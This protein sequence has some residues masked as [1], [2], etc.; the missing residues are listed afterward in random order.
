L[1]FLAE[2]EV[3]KR[4]LEDV[5]LA[6]KIAQTEP[7]RSLIAQ[8]LNPGIQ[9]TSDEDILAS[10]KN[11][12]D[13]YEHPFSSAPMGPESSKTAAVDFSGK[14]YRVKGLRVVDASIFPDAVSEA[15]NP[16]VIMTAEKIAD[17]I[18]NKLDKQLLK[19]L[20]QINR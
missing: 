11:T 17:E 14:V 2:E 10:I 7:L 9:V 13:S 4:I 19:T 8:E 12:L 15:P 5:K 16:T 18:K 3:R 20:T 1:N 6:R